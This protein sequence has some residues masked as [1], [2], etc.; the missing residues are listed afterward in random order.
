MF[1]RAASCDITD[2][3]TFSVYKR[4]CKCSIGLRSVRW[5]WRKDHD[6][7]DPLVFFGIPVALARFWGVSG[8]IIL[9]QYDS[10]S[11]KMQPRGYSVSLN[12]WLVLL[13]GQGV[14][15]SVQVSNSRI[16]QTP[17]D[18]NIPTTMFH[19]WFNTWWYHSFPSWE[20]IYKLLL[21]LWDHYKTAFFWQFFC[22]LESCVLY[23][24]NSV[25]VMKFWSA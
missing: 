13:L 5:L 9:L 15:T 16:D 14:V 10:L 2:C 11:T 7:Q 22:W 4:L 23:L 1:Q 25:S 8:A 21:I 19:C 17:P 20:V 6:S 3:L 12:S 18:L 24:T